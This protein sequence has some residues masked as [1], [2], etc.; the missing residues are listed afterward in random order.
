MIKGEKFHEFSPFSKF[1]DQNGNLTAPD[2]KPAHRMLFFRIPWLS[3]NKK[4]GAKIAPRL[5]RK[6]DF[7][8]RIRR[9]AVDHLL[10][11]FLHLLQVGGHHSK[12]NFTVQRLIKLSSAG[13]VELQRIGIA[14]VAGS[15][16]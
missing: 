7:P 1:S 2:K 5:R 14:V 4:R 6:S 15:Q 11:G 3:K 8:V 13:I 10:A 12:F 9:F 16:R